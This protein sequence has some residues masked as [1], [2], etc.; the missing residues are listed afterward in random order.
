M[1]T[2]DL[3]NK[4][5]CRICGERIKQPVG[6]GRPR[7]SCHKPECVNAVENERRKVWR[8]LQKV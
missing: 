3:T 1:G 2:D 7:K 6:R 8:K 5:F 4:V